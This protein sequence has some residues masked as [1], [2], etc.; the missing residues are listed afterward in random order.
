M[1]EMLLHPPA[2]RLDMSTGALRLPRSRSRVLDFRADCR[3]SSL[4]PFVVT[5]PSIPSPPPPPPPPFCRRKEAFRAPPPRPPSDLCSSKF[6]RGPRWASGA[7]PTSSSFLPECLF[8]LCTAARFVLVLQF[9]FL[10][11]TGALSQLWP[12]RKH[13]VALS[14]LKTST[15]G[16]VRMYHR[17]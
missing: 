8:C 9:Y 3:T 10:I 14:G 15:S 4:L 17:T 11:E 16:S 1:P 2:A 6:V 7:G 12:S 5:S 13:F